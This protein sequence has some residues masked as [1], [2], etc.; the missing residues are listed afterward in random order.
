M[1]RKQVVEV[2]ETDFEH[3]TKTLHFEDF[4]GNKVTEIITV[5]LKTQ[6]GGTPSSGTERVARLAYIDGNTVSFPSTGPVPLDGY[7]NNF[8]STNGN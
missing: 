6:G 7:L 3:K 1:T 4:R 8:M 2:K 5:E